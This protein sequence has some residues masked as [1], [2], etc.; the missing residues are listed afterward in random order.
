MSLIASEGWYNDGGWDA[1]PDEA[2]TSL[3]SSLIC[4]VRTTMGC[5][6]EAA[7]DSPIYGKYV[8]RWLQFGVLW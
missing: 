7:G 3:D 8:G 1:G 2:K 6:A 4:Y 5:L